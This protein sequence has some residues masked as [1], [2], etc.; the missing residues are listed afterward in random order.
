VDAAAARLTDAHPV[1]REGAKKV[2]GQVP[3]IVVV[4]SGE[5]GYPGLAF[6]EHDQGVE[7]G[8]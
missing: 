3:E 5:G 4:R 6:G 7:Q 1:L 2:T 8:H